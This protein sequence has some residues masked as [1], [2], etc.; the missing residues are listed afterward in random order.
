MKAAHLQQASTFEE[1]LLGSNVVPFANDGEHHYYVMEIKPESQVLVL[2]DKE[3]ITSFSDTNYDITQ[4]Q[5]SF[6]LIVLMAKIQLD[7]NFEKTDD[8]YKDGLEFFVGLKSGSNLIR[9]IAF[10]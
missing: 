4:I 2:F 1:T 3:I 6:L 8:S 5:N 9:E 7:D 10:F